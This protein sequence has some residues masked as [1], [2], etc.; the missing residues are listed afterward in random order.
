MYLACLVALG[1]SLDSADAECE[2]IGIAEYASALDGERLASG[3]NSGLSLL[4]H[5]A[6]YVQPSSP[7]SSLRDVGHRH[8]PR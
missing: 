6:R 3:G 8:R 2:N 7:S 5:R 4:H 1:A